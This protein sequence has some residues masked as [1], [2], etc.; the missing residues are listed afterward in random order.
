[1]Q[2]I[3]PIN[4]PRH[5]GDGNKD[6]I[7]VPCNKCIACLATRRE[8]WAFR[9][10]QELKV[11]QSASFITLTYEDENIPVSESGMTTLQKRDLQLFTKSLRKSN[12]K[13][14]WKYFPRVKTQKELL[15]MLP[16]LRY[17]SVGEYGTQ[18]WRPHYHS[19]MFNLTLGMEQKIEKIWKHGMTHVGEVTPASIRY[20]T[21]YV[22][23]KHSQMYTQDQEAAFSLMSNGLGSNY[24]TATKHHI[25]L[26]KLYVNTSSGSKI[27]MPKYY[28]DKMFNDQDTLFVKK[29][30]QIKHG[31]IS[32]QKHEKERQRLIKLGNIPEKYK[33]D[34]L[35]N[36]IE[37]MTKNSSKK[38]IL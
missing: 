32:D 23:A 37:K 22:I 13:Q 6:R 17:Y 4:L 25:N 29:K 9:L 16:K 11:A 26:E 31:L 35:N 10:E 8:Q 12:L 7:V 5:G 30:A 19:I 2:C 21:K 14:A 27:A 38:D 20:V 1:M 3:S 18:T 33:I 24:L 34:Q 36:K 15:K 28:Q